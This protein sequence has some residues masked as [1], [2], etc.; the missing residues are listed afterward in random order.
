M[1]AKQIVSK[2]MICHS[3]LRWDFVYQR[4]QHLL[5]RFAKTAPVYFYEEPIFEETA[6]S[7]LSISSR[8]TNLN[9]VVPH[10][11]PNLD[12]DQIERA[13]IALFDQFIAEF[14]L[15]ETI[16]WYYT[17]MALKYS[18]RHS[19]K[20]IIYDCMDELSG[21]KFADSKISNYEQQLF[22]LADVVFTG[23][24][25]LYQ[26]KRKYHNN[27]HPFPSSIEKEHF[28]KA[29]TCAEAAD[30]RMI[31]G[32]KIGFF[33]VIDERFDTQLIKDLAIAKPE[34]NIVLIGPVVKIDPA[35]LPQ[36]PNIHYLGQKSYSELPTYLA[37]W[38]VAMLPFL[39][40]ESTRFISPTKTPEYLAAGIPVVSTPIHDV[41]HP[42]ADEGLV[43]ICPCSNS[44]AKAIERELNEVDKGTW[45]NRI[46]EFL[47]DISWDRTQE[48]MAKQINACV[49]AKQQISI[50]S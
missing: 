46:D 24:H 48:D 34:W 41:I 17:P 42:Y 44:F 49:A 12:Q 14:D 27:I 30:Q 10:L 35:T 31:K 26:A 37:G 47:Q 18:G 20:A 28:A 8:G 21:F 36:L 6:E 43:H 25:S 22:A 5:T 39:L 13:L 33:G 40:N 23:G 50:A 38:Q 1:K 7:Y 4:P 19:P 16:F 11:Q 15:A 3:H 32:P 9:I 2:G 45:R 29:K